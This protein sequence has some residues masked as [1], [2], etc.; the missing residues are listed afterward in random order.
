[1]PRVIKPGT[2]NAFRA[3]GDA[4]RVTDLQKQLK[5]AKGNRSIEIG[6]QLLKARRA[7]NG[8]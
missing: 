1:M 5:T 8:A 7:M 4:E 3:N 6:A 2:G